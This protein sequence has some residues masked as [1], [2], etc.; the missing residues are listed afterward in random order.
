MNTFKPRNLAKRPP[1]KIVLV[2]AGTLS[3]LVLIAMLVPTIRRPL[4]RSIGFAAGEPLRCEPEAGMHAAY[5]I[6]MHTQLK[7]NPTALLLDPRAVGQM[8]SSD[9][10]F[11]ARLLVHAVEARKGGMLMV[12]ALDDLEADGG[13]LDLPKDEIAQLTMPFYSVLTHDCRFGEFGF[14]KSVSDD[15][16]N[17][18]QS[19]MQGLSLSMAENASKLAWTSREY[20]SVGQYA[21]NYERP[22]VESHTVTKQRQ[23][24][25]RM[26]PP[27]GFAIKEPLLVRVLESSTPA[28]LDDDFAWLTRFESREHLQITR[29]QG[30]VVADLKLSLW[31]ERSSEEVPA[32][33]LADATAELRWRK[34]NDAPLVTTPSQPDPPD[35]MKTMPLEVAMAEYTAIMRSGVQGAALKGADYL[36]LYLRARPEMAFELMNL[37]AK[38]VVPPDL[39]STLFLGL[40]L[41]GTPEAHDALIAGL[42]DEHSS[43]NRARAAAALPDIP[44]PAVKTLEALQE[45]AKNA[46]S[47]DPESTRLVRN[48]ASYAIGTL[49]QRTRVANPA[50]SKQALG[51][52]SSTLSSAR[53]DQQRT[54]ALDAISN[55]GNAALLAS[56]K[57]LLDSPETLVRTHAIQAM[58]HMDPQVNKQMFGELIKDEPEARVRGTIAVTYAEQ[59]KRA[60]QAPP[61]EVLDAAIEQLSH[62]SDPRVKGLL[63][64]LIGPACATYAY[65]QKSLGAQFQRETDPILLKLIGKWVPGDRLGM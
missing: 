35:A 48:S 24:Y 15:V 49:E 30:A 14:D 34:E 7:I 38:R 3:L 44:K 18:A 20:D 27:S 60:N 9:A 1:L 16:V 29:T 61:S 12:L 54:T 47:D 36:A 41:A 13:S 8:V 26:H 2:V 50:L 53:D 59:A 43:T 5:R 57:P 55:S 10:G 64:E 56:V 22:D 28:T 4:A 31:L 63:I 25:L 23:A 40:E 32:V 33:V 37:L 6:R 58:G 46:V 51:E 45:T 62:E 42:S 11:S 19:L 17:R 52:L 39:E 65:A 21:A